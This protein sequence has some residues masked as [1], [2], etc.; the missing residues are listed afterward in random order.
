MPAAE[1]LPRPRLSRGAREAIIVSLVGNGVLVVAKLWLGWRADSLAVV[2]DGFH[3]L[4]DSFTTLLVLLGLWAA[5]KAPDKSHPY[6]HGRAEYVGTLVLATLLVVVGF[7]LARTAVDRLR[8]HDAA[9]VD[10]SWLL[11]VVLLATVPAKEWMARYTQARARTDE[12]H[13]LAADALH[14]RL[15]S[16]TSL[17]VAAGLLGVRAGYGWLDDLLAVA[18]SLVVALSGLALGAGAA[19]RLLG[20]EADPVLRARLVEAS[21]SVAGVREPHEICVHDYGATV[22]VSLHAY[23][24]GDLTLR[25]AHALTETMEARLRAVVRGPV[26]VHLEPWPESDETRHSGEQN[27]L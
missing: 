23:V 18:V 7:E 5:T 21:A 20:R 9:T 14:H 26:V 2:A 19:H 24:D 25:A 22:A 4:A 13:L 10:A 6:G 3:S 1:A 27:H 15:D 12:S 16:L 11:I 8:D 17:A